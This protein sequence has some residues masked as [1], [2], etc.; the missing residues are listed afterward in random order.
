MGNM[1][2]TYLITE[3]GMQYEMELD[4][5]MVIQ[6]KDLLTGRMVKGLVEDGTALKRYLFPLSLVDPDM[7]I[8]VIAEKFDC[9]DP[10]DRRFHGG[11]RIFMHPDQ[12]G[13]AEQYPEYFL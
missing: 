7:P 13:M 1:R 9:D 6:Q 2:R 11:I 3:A 8:F 10:Y 4:G 12:N 5:S